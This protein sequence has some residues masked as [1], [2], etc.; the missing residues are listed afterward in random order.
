M[1]Q[2]SLRLWRQCQWSDSEAASFF[3]RDKDLVQFTGDALH[4]HQ[5]EFTAHM[6]V[7]RYDHESLIHE[8]YGRDCMASLIYFQ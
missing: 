8:F 3:Q 7:H 2:R 1:D 6:L 5:G 4:L